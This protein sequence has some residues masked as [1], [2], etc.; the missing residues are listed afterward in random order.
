MVG[1]EASPQAFASF[2]LSGENSVWIDFLAVSGFLVGNCR[3]IVGGEGI[4]AC[5]NLSSFRIIALVVLILMSNN[6]ECRRWRN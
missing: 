5:I 2:L 6:L 3:Q 4:S 1:A